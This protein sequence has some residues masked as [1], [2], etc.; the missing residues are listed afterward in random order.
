[1]SSKLKLQFPESSIEQHQYLCWQMKQAWVPEPHSSLTP[2][3]PASTCREVVDLTSSL[4]P[5]VGLYIV[6]D[7]ATV[8]DLRSIIELQ[9]T[10]SSSEWSSTVSLIQAVSTGILRG[11]GRQYIG[12][13][14]VFVSYIFFAL[15]TGISLMFLTTLRL[16]GKIRTLDVVQSACPTIPAQ[17]KCLHHPNFA[18]LWWSLATAMIVNSFVYLL[19][20]ARTNWEQQAEDASHRVKGTT[21]THYDEKS[22]I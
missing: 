20:L 15:P 19:I 21:S 22:G 1:M 3:F 9:I 6:F 12:A 2:Q 18:G 4:L 14:V 10:A 7:G 8:S 13:G 16:S 11:C 5:I 17:Q